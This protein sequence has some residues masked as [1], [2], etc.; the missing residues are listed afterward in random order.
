MGREIDLLLAEFLH[1]ERDVRLGDLVTM[2]IE[3]GRLDKPLYEIVSARGLLDAEV[4]EAIDAKLGLDLRETFIMPARDVAP[5]ARL[6]PAGSLLAPDGDRYTMGTVL[7]KG[8]MGEVHLAKDHLLQREVALKCLLPHLSTDD[9]AGDRLVLEARVTGFLEHPSIIP[10]HDLGLL[11]EQGTPYYTMRIAREH[12]LKDVLVGRHSGH[13]SPSLSQLVAILKQVA[14]A[15]H[16]AH[17]NGVIHLDLKPANILIGSYGEVFLTDWGIAR[18]L[19]TRFSEQALRH[20]ARPGTLLGTLRYMAPEQA[21]GELDQVDARTDVYALG[22]VLYEV[23]TCSP[24]FE[25]DN[26]LAMIFKTTREEPMPPSLRAPDRFIPRDLEEICLR[27]INKHPEDRYPSAQHFANELQAYLDGE[28]EH[29][30]RREHALVALDLGQRARTLYDGA[31]QDYQVAVE[32]LSKQR[33]EV[34]SWAGFDEKQALWEL[35]ERVGQLRVRI[36]KEFG[37]AVR[38]FGQA[39]GHQPDMAEAREAMADLYQERFQ[40]AEALKD[41]GGAAYFENLVHQY[42]DGRY[43]A[44]LAGG[45][46]LSL[47]VERD[48]ARAQLFRYITRKGRL[49]EEPL[50]Q[51]R[52]P[53]HNQTIPHGSYV[54]V[55]TCEGYAPVRL[56]FVAKRTE[57]VALEIAL[58]E[59]VLLPQDFVI[60]SAGPF[61]TGRIDP[62][63]LK[64]AFDDV[65]T[66]AIARHPVTCGQYLEF[67][68]DLPPAQALAHAPRLTD[69]KKPYFE[70]LEDGTYVLPVRDREGDQWHP[71]WPVCMIN[72]HDAKTYA[73]WRSLRDGRPYGLPTSAQWEKAARG[74]DGRLYPWGDFFDPAFCNMGS[75]HKGRPLPAPVG[76]YPTDCSPYGAHDFSGGICE[77]TS[78]YACEP[79]DT[80][81][82]RGGCFSS[83][84]LMCR[85]DSHMSSPPRFRHPHYGMRL[86]LDL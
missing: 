3:A 73:R 56:P 19:N 63:G 28:K 61:I 45:A 72:L 83:I 20:Q 30:R 43:D 71:L 76:S 37:E 10:V 29:S 27:A 23:L 62:H 86:V 5:Q 17:D 24:V 80:M 9:E 55:I 79:D 65:P 82:L 77:W 21:R 39:L 25:A 64:P 70:C 8:G 58:F 50:V 4:I 69:E 47:S 12:S 74:V 42:Q 60:V 40:Q 75:S 7:G 26:T 6:E 13:E 34:P 31:R 46:T 2:A 18:V 52:L 85:L 35:E 15:V 78:T 48:N 1:S 81:V 41:P 14:L 53:C 16:F 68:N 44:L 51:L 59:E 22:A 54:A 84:D 32:K 67:L 66:F 11:S 49:F 36:Q 38:H 33:A 57:H